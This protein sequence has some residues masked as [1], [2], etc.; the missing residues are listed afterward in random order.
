V[1]LLPNPDLTSQTNNWYNRTG[2]FPFF[3]TFTS[4]AKLDHSV[5]TKQKIQ[6]T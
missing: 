5:S 2:A 1:A 6:L 4:T 3:N